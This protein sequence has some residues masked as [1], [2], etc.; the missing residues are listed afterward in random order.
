MQEQHQ[1]WQAIAMDF[2][3]LNYLAKFNIG[4][5]LNLIPR[6]YQ[7]IET[8]LQEEDLE[9]FIFK[10]VYKTQKPQQFVQLIYKA[11]YGDK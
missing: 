11:L 8:Y 5:E 1:I 10:R 4:V 6:E 7:N 3:K 2:L 9:Y